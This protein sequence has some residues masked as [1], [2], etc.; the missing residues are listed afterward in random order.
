MESSPHSGAIHD[1]PGES[2]G[3]RNLVAFNN[4][5]L[6]TLFSEVRGQCIRLVL[7]PMFEEL[8]F[9]DDEHVARAL[10]QL[11]HLRAPRV[12]RRTAQL[13]DAR[14]PFEIELSQLCDDEFRRRYRL[15]RELFTSLLH[16]CIR[17]QHWPHAFY[18][19]H[20][21]PSVWLAM[22]LEQLGTGDSS[23]SVCH[24]HFVSESAFSEHRCSVLLSIIE[25]L[26]QDDTARFGWPAL[27]D[28]EGW[29]NLARGFV[30]SATS[31][32]AA[33]AGTVAAGDGTLVPIQPW[34]ICNKEMNVYRCRK[35]LPPSSALAPP[36]T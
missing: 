35:V 30:P 16:R 26:V 17:S 8:L 24:H 7:L 15:P 32:F 9:D 27:D 11:H 2:V 14:L 10:W 36:S 3:Q 12:N 4:N 1:A 18:P 31:R 28:S 6:F 23:A 34:K 22:V 13:D 21:S 5:S 19:T 25:V 29:G 33:F 20:I